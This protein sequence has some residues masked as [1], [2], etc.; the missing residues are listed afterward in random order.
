MTVNMNASMR[1]P[2]CNLWVDH[3]A[4]TTLSAVAA[5]TNSRRRARGERLYV[6]P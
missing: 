5:K 4:E 1:P 2:F 3:A 6:T